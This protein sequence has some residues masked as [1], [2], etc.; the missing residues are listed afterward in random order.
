MIKDNNVKR[1]IEGRI[2][3]GTKEGRKDGKNDRQLEIPRKPKGCVKMKIHIYFP[4]GSLKSS[5]YIAMTL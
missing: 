1:E 3:R 4:L 5:I 2:E